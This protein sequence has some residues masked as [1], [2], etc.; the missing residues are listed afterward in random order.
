M[1]RLFVVMSLLLTS[2]VGNLSC[3]IQATETDGDYVLFIYDFVDASYQHYLR[4][5]MR[6]TSKDISNPQLCFSKTHFKKLIKLLEKN[7]PTLKKWE[8]TATD[9]GVKNYEKKFDLIGIPVD[10]AYYTFENKVWFSEYQPNGLGIYSERL[11]ARFY[12]RDDGMSVLMLTSPQGKKRISDGGTTIE[13]TTTANTGAFGTKQVV[14]QA[15]TKTYKMADCGDFFLV[16][17]LKDIDSFINQ[18][19]DAMN[20]FEKQKEVDNLFK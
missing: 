1:K 13:S 6:S 11:Y 16:I 3:Q 2:I 15:V 20:G 7:A 8:K 17:P 9:E 14:G 4:F 5:S 18:L 12:V 10:R 19:K